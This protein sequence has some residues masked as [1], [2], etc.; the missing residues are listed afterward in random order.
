MKNPENLTPNQQAQL[1]YIVKSNPELYAAYLGKE[2][3]R[4]VFRQDS[5]KAAC[6]ALGRWLKWARHCGIPEFEALAEKIDR[7]RKF[8]IATVRY[9]MS[10]GKLEATNNVIKSIIR[11]SFGFRNVDNL[12]AMILW[13]T[14]DVVDLAESALFHLIG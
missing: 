10:T 3:L 7:N 8:I 4:L 12:I 13:R 11:R 6:L 9:G 14:S 5:F 1:D 2:R